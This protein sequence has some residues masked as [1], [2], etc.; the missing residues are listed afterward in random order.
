MEQYPDILLENPQFRLTVG[1]DAL[2]KSLVHKASGRELAAG[3]EEIALFS[4]TQTRPFQNE[5]KLAHMNKQTTF[6]ANRLRWEDGRLIVGFEI[7]PYEAAVEVK[8]TEQYMTFTLTEFLV[9]DEPYYWLYMD[10]PPA[11]SFRLLQLPLVHMEN[12]GQWLNVC[13]DEQVAVNVLATSPYEMIDSEKSKRCRTLTADARKDVKLLG[14]T[15]ALIVTE[16]AA[17]MDAVAAVEED[18]D[19]PRGVKSRRD[20]LIDATIYAGMDVTP[21]NID[22]HIEWA[23]KGG[24]KLFRM[25]IESFIHSGYAGSGDYDDSGFKPEY[26]NGMADLKLI[27][28]KIRAAGMIP[29]LHFLQTFIGHKSHYFTPEVDPR[30]NIKEHFT[31]TKPLSETDTVIYVD[32]STMNCPSRK[33]RERIQLLNFGGEVIHYESFSTEAPW[34]FTGCQRGYL[35]TNVKTHPAGQIGGVLDVCEYGAMSSYI[36]QKTDLQDEIAEALAKLYDCGFEFVYFDGSEGTAAPYEFQVPYA[37]Y[38]VYRK[39]GKAPIFCEGAAKAHFSWHMLSGANAF[40]V[41][42]PA[43][44]KAMIDE[45]PVKEA[46]MMAKDFTRVNFGWWRVFEDTQPDTFEYG[47]S[48]AISWNC[49]GA[50]MSQLEDYE[51]SPRVA[52]AFE[53]LRRWEDARAKGYLTAERRA[54]L[55]QAGTQEYTMLV[56]ERG[57]YELTAW[58]HLP[59]AAGDE[60]AVR[61]FTF[62]RGGESWAA[63][64]S[65]RGAARMHLPLRAEDVR[66][67]KEIGGQALALEETEGGVSMEVAGRAY[68]HTALPMQA[69]EQALLTAAVLD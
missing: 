61:V 42:V 56:D 4:V 59:G 32:H 44:F 12:F 55:R 50:V 51:G 38:R 46:A 15:A 60:T 40:D 9:P 53:V 57:A 65:P 54:M 68:L 24:F 41:W 21:A 17:L 18:F 19:L 29:G 62:L 25:Y 14:T 34:C 35:N 10:I 47:C 7:I 67:E 30:V 6:Q 2:V 23:K 22:A 58:K 36:D 5:V 11:Q 64:W 26:P 37:Q 31:L 1:A 49:P 52:D 8:A 69:L 63:I 20:P 39:L 33:G 45:H 3:D 48:R 43:V 27:A 28:D 13:W 66:Y 16:T